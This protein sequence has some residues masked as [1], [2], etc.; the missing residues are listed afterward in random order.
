MRS[1][2]NLAL[3]LHRSGQVRS[4]KD[5]IVITPPMC[6]A[7]QQ[8]RRLVN[9][10]DHAIGWNVLLGAGEPREGGEKIHFMDHVADDLTRLDHGPATAQWQ[11]HAHRPR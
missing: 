6:I 10:I 3:N 5:K 7:L 2:V 9:T 1:P 11:Q 4:L 8:Q